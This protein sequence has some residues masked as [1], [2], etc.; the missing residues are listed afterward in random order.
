MNFL[1][2]NIE[3]L[4]NFLD[5][6]FEHLLCIIAFILI[7]VI[8][9]ALLSTFPCTMP[10]EVQSQEIYIFGI[11]LNNLSIWFTAIC[12]IVTAFW[13]M[14]Q[15]T[16]SK[17]LK[18]Q[19]K[20]SEIAQNFADNLIERMGIIY[21][22]LMPN[23]EIQNM[24]KKL[25]TTKLRQFTVQE[26]LEILNDKQCFNK[27]NAIIHSKRTQNRYNKI[28]DSRYNTR[29]QEKF[30][31]IFP[32]LIDNTLNKL[33]A[34]C[35]NIS[36]QAAGSQFIYESLHQIFLS[37]VEIL[38]IRISDSNTDNVDKYYIHIVSVYN[39]WKL[40]KQKDIKKFNKT[41][42]KIDKLKKQ[43]NNEIKKLLNKPIKTV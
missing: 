20:A 1:K 41:K 34:I 23:T 32:L 15:Y 3:H 17:V 27:F 13:S 31:S 28:L 29:E 38:S 4:G 22:V 11:S 39:M 10:K 8:C 26:M 35:I 21:D 42:K 36:S 18:Q 24:I 19:E 43:A 16:K 25:D 14:Y 33:E 5:Y 37:T 30:D 40:Q 12:L 9:F 2:K 7:L 6:L